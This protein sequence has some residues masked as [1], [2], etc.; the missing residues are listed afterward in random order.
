MR[1]G[2]VVGEELLESSGGQGV[3]KESAHPYPYPTSQDAARATRII[4]LVDQLLKV[5]KDEERREFFR[6]IRE[7]AVQATKAYPAPSAAGEESSSGSLPDRITKVRETLRRI[8]GALGLDDVKSAD[9]PELGREVNELRKR[10]DV[11]AGIVPED[12]GKEKVS[13]RGMV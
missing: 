10:I 12:D 9:I 13:W 1:D 8:A 3:R 4:A 6:Q 7:V 5:E 2:T 11:L